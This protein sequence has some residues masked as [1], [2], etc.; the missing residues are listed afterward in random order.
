MEQP[1]A[2]ALVIEPDLGALGPLELRCVRD[3]TI[4][5]EGVGRITFPGETDCLGLDLERLVRMEVG[6]VLVY[7]ETGFKPPVGEGLNK[8]AVVTMHQCY[9]PNSGRMLQDP[10]AQER[11]KRKIKQMTEEKQAT[12]IDYDCITG[13]WEFS[14]DHF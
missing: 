8:P 6:E 1:G 14:V 5:R 4:S 3:L 7:P 13:V 12:F 9:P 10:K 11:Y 2:P